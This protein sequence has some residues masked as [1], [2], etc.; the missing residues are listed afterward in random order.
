MIR[1]NGLRLGICAA[2]LALVIAPLISSDSDAKGGRG[3]GGG[4]GGGR[5]GH[6][7]GHSISIGRSVHS[8][9]AMRSLSRVHSAPTRSVG[10]IRTGRSTLT[11]HS[12]TTTS[13]NVTTTSHSVTNPTATPNVVR[14]NGRTPAGALHNNAFASLSKNNVHDRALARATFRGRFAQ[15]NWNVS[16]LGWNWRHRHPFIVIGWFGPLFW[17]FAYWDLVNYTYWPYAYDVFWPRAYDDLYVGMFGPYAYEGPYYGGTR[18][19][20][21]TRASQQASTIVCGERV[22][23]VTDWPIQQI[24]QTIEPDQVQEAALNDLK[25]GAAKAL[26]AL[27]SA[28]P[29]DLPSTPPGRFA[30]MRKRVETMLAALGMVRPPLERL[31]DSLSDEQ[32]ARFN[33]V[34]PE[35]AVARTTRRGNPSPDLAQVCGAQAAKA[36]DVPTDR[37]ERELRPTE[38]QLISLNKLNDAARR[39]ADILSARCPTGQMLTPPGRVA[40]MEQRLSS[41]LEAIKIVQPALEDFYGS[42]NDEQKARFNVLGAQQS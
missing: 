6:G 26:Q 2:A 21:R 3:G 24:A 41:M 8:A 15:R 12:G 32:K 30:T 18:T 4:G 23:A 19:S 34:T 39:A 29:D 11:S 35:T 13:H 9:P 40:A 14:S 36:T 5:G 22:P 33:A 27:Q 10:S 20:R 37:L 31:Y 16:H 1:S 25:D 7:G 38:A 28:C 17:P 42:L